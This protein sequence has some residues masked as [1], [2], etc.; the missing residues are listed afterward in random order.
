M[1]R[2]WGV[3]LLLACVALTAGASSAAAV[4]FHSAATPEY[5]HA[6]QLESTKFRFPSTH[7]GEFFL[8]PICTSGDASG[9][10]TA[11]TVEQVELLPTYSGCTSQALP[12]SVSANGCGYVVTPFASG[13]EFK[14]NLKIVCPAE[15]TIV[16]NF[17]SFLQVCQILIGAQTP[18]ESSFTLLNEGVPGQV[19]LTGTAKGI[20]YATAPESGNS[21]CG[22]PKNNAEVVLAL[23]LKGYSDEALTKQVSFRVE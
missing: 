3:L 15:K 22:L 14:A 21:N 11:S 10:T 13:K 6:Q 2:A 5:L 19:R 20:T 16:F 4:S 9:K 8:E 12:L 17:F 18:A 7:F 1:V 23:A